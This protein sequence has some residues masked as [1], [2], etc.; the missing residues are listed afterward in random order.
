MQDSEGPYE[1]LQVYPQAEREVIQAA[2]R[3]L[4]FKYHPDRNPS[5]RATLD[6]QE[7][8]HAY[9]VLS[10]PTRRAKYNSVRNAGNATDTEPT[11]GVRSAAAGAR[12]DRVAPPEATGEPRAPTPAPVEDSA[13]VD[14]TIA[15]PDRPRFALRLPSWVIILIA[16]GAIGGLITELII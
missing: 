10:D 12:E 13:Q 5:P 3:C 8:N 2:Y 16:L 15:Y 7:L 6:L 11:E 9:A 14:F 1:L 4:V